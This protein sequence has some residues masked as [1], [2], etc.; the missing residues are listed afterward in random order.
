M[1]GGHIHMLEYPA[2]ALS[3][4]AAK[5]ACLVWLRL[6]HVKRLDPSPNESCRLH[7]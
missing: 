7:R 6:A 4:A 5:H 1:G 2:L 3:Y